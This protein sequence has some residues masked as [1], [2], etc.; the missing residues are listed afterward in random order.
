MR[1]SHAAQCLIALAIFAMPLT[2]AGIARASDAPVHLTA[3]YEGAPLDGRIR[4]PAAALLWCK[5]RHRRPVHCAGVLDFW[6]M[7]RLPRNLDRSRSL[8]RR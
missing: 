7:D 6:N 1:P 3:G 8:L 5:S 4:R 2:I